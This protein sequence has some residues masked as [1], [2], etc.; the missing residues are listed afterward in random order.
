MQYEHMIAPSQRQ[1]LR[2]CLLHMHVQHKRREE[3]SDL[4][5]HSPELKF[6]SWVGI[7]STLIGFDCDPIGLFAV[8]NEAVELS[9]LVGDSGR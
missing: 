5:R 2:V 3:G 7:R 4:D 9:G 1:V 8:W 6:T